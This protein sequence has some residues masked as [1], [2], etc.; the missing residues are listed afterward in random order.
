VGND[1]STA[2][3]MKA[4]IDSDGGVKGGYS[5]VCKVDERSQNMTKHSLTGIQ[6]LNNLLGYK[7]GPGKVFSAASLAR[8]ATPQGPKSL[9]VHQAFNSPDILT[10]VFRAS[11]STREK[12][13]AAA[14]MEPI[15]AEGIQLEEE[16]KIV[17]FRCPEEGCIMV[18]Q[19][20]SSLQRHLDAGKP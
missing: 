3:D 10:A 5:A 4:A 2:S 20:Y 17:V 8:L 16:E 13:P 1:V 19:S 14:P 12:Q 18:Y 15:A 7:V 9:Q 11:S 6:F